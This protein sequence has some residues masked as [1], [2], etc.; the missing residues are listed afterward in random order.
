MML[1][2]MVTYLEWYIVKHMHQIYIS[3]LIMD[4]EL[5]HAFS[6]F[7]FW[8]YENGIWFYVETTSA[9]FQERWSLSHCNNRFLR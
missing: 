8:P 3:D 4:S 9:V 7:T 1:K 2:Y 6:V 5:A